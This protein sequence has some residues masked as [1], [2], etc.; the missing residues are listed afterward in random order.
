MQRWSDESNVW[1]Q[2]SDT[3]RKWRAAE[4]QQEAIKCG[5]GVNEEFTL[6]HCTAAG[7]RRDGKQLIHRMGDGTHTVHWLRWLLWT[8]KEMLL[9]YYD[10]IL[11][12]K[13]CNFEIVLA[14]FPHLDTFYTFFRRFKN[15]CVLAK[16]KHKNVP[17]RQGGWRLF[18]MWGACVD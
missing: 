3:R 7:S 12:G 14:S 11:S 15:I 1:H 18:D 9:F 13:V 16:I 5:A 4:Q 2:S 8:L 10:N 6:A 17:C